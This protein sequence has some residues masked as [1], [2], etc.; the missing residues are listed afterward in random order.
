MRI[1]FLEVPT[2]AQARESVLRLQ[3]EANDLTQYRSS[4]KALLAAAKTAYKAGRSEDLQSTIDLTEQRLSEV[5]V[6]LQAARAELAFVQKLAEEQALLKT[7]SW[8]GSLIY[9][10]SG[11]DVEI[12]L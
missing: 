12:E 6:K 3:K 10:L 9:R 2:M 1:E 11:G 7:N 4:L 8:L 5:K